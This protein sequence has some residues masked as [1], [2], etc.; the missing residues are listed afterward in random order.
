MADGN[1]DLCADGRHRVDAGRLHLLLAHLSA[2]PRQAV[3]PRFPGAFPLWGI[4]LRLSKTK[5]RSK[6]HTAFC[7]LYQLS[8]GGAGNSICGYVAEGWNGSQ[9]FEEMQG[10]G[11]AADVVTCCSLI[12]ALERGEQ[13]GLAEA[14]FLKMT[15]AIHPQAWHSYHFQDLAMLRAHHAG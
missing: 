4:L 1:G 13:L 12:S 8:P 9:A 10:R 7:A 15:S 5:S 6:C 2:R 3:A 11:V 14:F